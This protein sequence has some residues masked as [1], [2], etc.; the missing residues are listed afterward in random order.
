MFLSIKKTADQIDVIE[1]HPENIKRI[2]DSQCCQHDS[3]T[4]DEIKVWELHDPDSQGRKNE[5]YE[6]LHP[7]PEWMCSPVAP[8]SKKRAVREKFIREIKHIKIKFRKFPL[9]RRK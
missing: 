3:Y 7:V 9:R 4:S 5:A 1:L 8:V 2:V 6:T